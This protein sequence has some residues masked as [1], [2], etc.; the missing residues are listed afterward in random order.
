MA[1]YERSVASGQPL[2]ANM[3]LHLVQIDVQLG[4]PERALKRIEALRAEGQ[5]GPSA[6]QLAVL[7]LQEMGKADEARK[8]LDEARRQYPLSDELVKVDAALAPRRNSRY[9]EGRPHPRRVPR[10][11]DPRNVA[12]SP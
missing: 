3:Q 2:N 4:Q 7:T 10:A 1:E 5:V 12:A 8:A 11:R 9:P 6:E